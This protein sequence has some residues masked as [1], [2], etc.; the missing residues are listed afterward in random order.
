MIVQ[1]GDLVV[2]KLGE[3]NTAGIV[4]KAAELPKGSRDT[5]LQGIFSV[6]FSTTPD[7]LFT[8]VVTRNQQGVGLSFD[9]MPN[10]YNFEPYL[11]AITRKEEV[12]WK[13]EV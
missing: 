9:Y 3:D 12:I 4:V 2:G 8:W 5:C 10:E 6:K 1:G 13:E 7:K 11:N